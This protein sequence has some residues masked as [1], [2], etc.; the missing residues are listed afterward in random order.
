MEEQTKGEVLIEGL[1]RIR[2]GL[3]MVA[4][5]GSHVDLVRQLTG[6]QTAAQR[7]REVMRS[8]TLVYNLVLAMVKARN[9]RLSEDTV[10]K[11]V[12]DFLDV[13]F[14]L[15]RPYRQVQPPA[16]AGESGVVAGGDA[17]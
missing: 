10:E 2:E 4:R 3:Q 5:L 9:S 16:A 17:V 15:S 7:L 11:V 14:D 13:L 6:S 1:E 8:E 12:R